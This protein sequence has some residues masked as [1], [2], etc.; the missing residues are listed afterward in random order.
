MSTDKDPKSISR[1][2]WLIVC[3]AN[4]ITDPELKKA[5]SLVK[6]RL[7]GRDYDAVKDTFDFFDKL[8]KRNYIHEGDTQLLRHIL[9]K[10]RREDLIEELDKYDSQ[11]AVIARH[12]RMHPAASEGPFIGREGQLNEIFSRLKEKNEYGVATICISGLPG[13]GKTRLA[14][15]ACY[16]QIEYHELLVVD[17]RELST[18]ESIC[19]A[20][21]HTLGEDASLNVDI[22]VVTL[23]LKK[24]RPNK[25]DGTVILFDNADRPL[26]TPKEGVNDDVYSNF[27]ELIERIIECGNNSLKVLITSREGF[28]QE[29]CTR[30]KIIS[31]TA[32]EL[33]YN[34]A[35]KILEYYSGNTEISNKEAKRLIQICGKCPLALKV[36]GSRLKDHTVQPNKLIEYLEKNPHDVTELGLPGEVNLE[37]CLSNTFYSLPKKQKLHLIRLSAF[38]GTFT[39]HAALAVFEKTPAEEVEVNLQLQDLKYRNLIE[40][41]VNETNKSEIRYGIHLLM[42]QFL[43]GVAEIDTS[44]TK[45]YNLAEQ[46]FVR[47]FLKDLKEIGTMSELRYKKAMKKKNDDAANFQKLLKLLQSQKRDIGVDEWRLISST[48]ELFYSTKERLKYFKAQ[49]ELA[50]QNQSTLEFVEMSAYEGLQMSRINHRYGDILPLFENAER[51]LLKPPE[52]K[53]VHLVKNFLTSMLSKLLPEKYFVEKP[54]HYLNA[55]EKET[56]VLLYQ[57]WGNVCTTCLEDLDM[58]NKRIQIAYALVKELNLRNTNTARF[59]STMADVILNNSRLQRASNLCEKSKIIEALEL[60]KKAY[61]LKKELTGSEN[62]P[63]IPVYLANIGSCYYQLE[64]IDDAIMYCKWSLRVEEEMLIDNEEGYVKTLRILALAYS[65]KNR[66]EDAIEYGK[67][68]L[69]RRVELLGIHTDTARAYYLLGSL[70]LKWKDRGNLKTAEQH[71]E[72]ALKVEEQLWKQDK[73]HSRD[74]ENLKRDMEKLLA[75]TDQKMKY[76]TY[77]RRFNMAETTINDS[78]TESDSSDSVDVEKMMEDF[79]KKAKPITLKR[80][81]STSIFDDECSPFVASRDSGISSMASVERHGKQRKKRKIKRENLP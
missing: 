9:S 26:K 79:E 41:F 19:Y 4:S 3:L 6:D 73:P 52:T 50:H 21:M 69:R 72:E 70:Y 59:Y 20:V 74:W 65:D 2:R 24:Y 25:S 49:R 8:Q 71:F 54:F 12:Y 37:A 23:K 28:P 64:K 56:L 62:H 45:H 81:H 55:E 57:Q 43:Q 53:E 22:D 51:M 36:I 13:M 5:K 66:Y 32:K 35:K 47:H 17:L 77:R 33:E 44:L 31:I 14:K 63:D 76:I 75:I 27:V 80:R 48:I 1:F 40:T 18:T 10:I 67:R 7:G 34:D 39:S 30:H 15:E 42:R 46:A 60:Y 58:A 38:P 11:Y 61:E 68:C 29:L 78:D 16:R